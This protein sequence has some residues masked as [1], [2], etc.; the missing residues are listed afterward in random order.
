MHY[1]FYDFFGLNKAI[2]TYINHATNI[3]ILPNILATISNIFFIENF[4]VYYFALCLY[5]YYRLKSD[6]HKVKKESLHSQK[7]QPDARFII[8]Y[9][10]LVTIGTCY[11]LLGFTYAAF[12]FGINMPRPFCS[13]TTSEFVTILDTSK[14]RCLSSFP[15]AHVGLAII[16]A[17]YLWPYLKNYQKTLATFLIILVGVSRITLAM[18]YPADII[19]SIIIA[20]ILIFFTS[21][22]VNILQIKVI[23][24]LGLIIYRLLF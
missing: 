3:S 7:S 18:H 2:F 13:L 10:K 4:A 20:F 22:T 11:A 8:T 19:Y 23:D 15:S 14:E 16:I 9:N 5:C 21:K 17:Y 24:R 1:I 12:K 6:Q